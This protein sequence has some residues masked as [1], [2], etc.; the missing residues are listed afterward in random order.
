MGNNSSTCLSC[1][2]F[3][4]TFCL[5]AYKLSAFLTRTSCRASFLNW[6]V[7]SSSVMF[8]PELWLVKYTV[9]NANIQNCKFVS[10]SVK[11]T[12]F[13]LLFLLW[14]YKPM[15]GSALSDMK[16]EKDIISYAIVLLNY[17][18]QLNLANRFAHAT[19]GE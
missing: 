3:L 2:V 9:A 19:F 1:F 13:V 6:N 15:D 5:P 7:F 14:I 16:S 11:C 4:N 10:T 8:Y 17:L 18:I 12:D